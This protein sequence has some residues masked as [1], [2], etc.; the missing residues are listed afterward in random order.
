MFIFHHSLN[1]RTSNYAFYVA[2][3]NLHKLGMVKIILW[4]RT[5]Q[6]LQGLMFSN[7]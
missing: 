2:F 3:Q 4:L 5:Y 1:L 7:G 6:P